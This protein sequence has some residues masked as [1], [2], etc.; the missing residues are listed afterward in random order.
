MHALAAASVVTGLLAVLAS[1]ADF[2]RGSAPVAVDG[3][4]NPDSAANPAVPDLMFETQVYP[5]LLMR[6]GGCHAE[7]QEAG[8]SRLLLT[9]NARQDRAMILSMVTPGEPAQSEL[10][11][12][13]TGGNSHMGGIR[14][15]PDSAEY[16]TVADWI[17]MLPPG[18]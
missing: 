16:A 9:G 12:T 11:L 3:G 17:A 4:A 18:P 6:C 5:V 14:L 1:C 13:G 2:H 10:L 7:W 15:L 8:L